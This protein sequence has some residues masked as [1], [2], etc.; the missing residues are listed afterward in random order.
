M[1]DIIKKVYSHYIS[2]NELLLKEK[3]ILSLK[4]IQEFKYIGRNINLYYNENYFIKIDHRSKNQEKY[5]LNDNS[6]MLGKFPKEIII[7]NILR[8]E[9]EQNIIKINNYYFNNTKQILIMENAGITFKDLIMKDKNNLELI[10]SKLYEI[11]ILLAILQHKFKFM[12]KDLKCENILMKETSSEFNEY[13]LDG[14]QYKIKSYGY[15]PVLIDMP[16]ST[17]FKIDNKDFEIYDIIKSTYV[18]NINK[19][20]KLINPKDFLNKYL[21][22]IRDVNK[23]N[24]SFDIYH[25]I[26]SINL[27][28][29]ISKIK[30]IKE[31]FNKSG[32]TSS[33]DYSESLMNPFKFIII[34]QL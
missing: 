29:D 32:F 31:Y 7:N 10:N 30:I 11:F 9:C 14:K 24:P 28:I 12:H 8:K 21:W 27:I 15:I 3:E 34:F 25:L 19:F 22:Y 33:Y 17:I 20:K 4:N 18:H 16:T 13:S 2:D 1:E 6:L 23:Y 5:I 26:V